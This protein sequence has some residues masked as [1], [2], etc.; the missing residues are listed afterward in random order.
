MEEI[1]KK[2][3]LSQPRSSFGLVKWLFTMTSLTYLVGQV[4]AYSHYTPAE[5]D[6][7]RK[8]LGE[9]FSLCTQVIGEHISFC[10]VESMYP[11]SRYKY[12]D[13]S[14][15]RFDCDLRREQIFTQYGLPE[16]DWDEC[17]RALTQEGSP[18]IEN[19]CFGPNC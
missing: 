5:K 12:K 6:Q 19:I 8:A 13:S 11:Q 15:R 7:I 1:N 2:N 3:F 4:D 10:M 14:V 17:N 18:Q 16:A 9:N